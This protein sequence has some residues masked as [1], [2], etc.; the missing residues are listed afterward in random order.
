LVEVAA[1]LKGCTRG[2]D[3]VARQGVDEFLMLL[4][5]LDPDEVEAATREVAERVH[6]AL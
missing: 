2:T 3:L 5:D 6:Q 4:A 1:R